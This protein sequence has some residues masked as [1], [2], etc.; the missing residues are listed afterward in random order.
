MIRVDAL[1]DTC[2]IPVVKTRRAIRELQAPGQIEVLVD[3]EIAAQNIEKMAAQMGYPSF[4]EKLPDAEGETIYRV[5]LEIAHPDASSKEEP[6][7]SNALQKIPGEAAAAAASVQENPAAGIPKMQ[8]A[9]NTIG[10]EDAPAS[11]GTVVVISS[12][13]MG[14]GEA[15]L[16]TAL[17]KSFL[18]A[19]DSLEELPQ[20]LLF[21]NGGAH[22]T[23][24][25]SASLED[26]RDMEAQ[27]VEIL[28]CG[29]CLDFYGLKEKLR[30]GSVTN[31]Y[32]IAELMLHA[33]KIV[34][35]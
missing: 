11:A 14:G 17:M 27:G 25:G 8:S 23:C 2:P 32:A 24:E 20:T 26:L 4:R 29:T 9:K 16:G 15:A 7:T 1:G 13:K 22:L 6:A 31:M 18:Y 19:L 10:T 3:N 30:V 12:D 28:T 33:D 21:Y 5:V 34:K 35:P